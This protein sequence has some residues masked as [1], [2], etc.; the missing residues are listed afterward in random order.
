MRAGTLFVIALIPGVAGLSPRVFGQ[1]LSVGVIGGASLT[2][3]APDV[4]T[5]VLPFR[6]RFWSPTRDWVAG[7]KLELRFQSHF[8]VEVDGMYRELHITWAAVLA[9]GSLN[10]V[11]PSPVV[12]WEF[13]V[14]A[15]YRF[16]WGRAAPF[17]EAGPSFRTTG[18][19]NSYPSHYGAAAG[20][21]VETRVA[22]VTIAPVVR[23]TRWAADIGYSWVARTRQN[24]VELLVG[25]SRA[26]GT[27]WSPLGGRV[28]LGAVAGWGLNADLPSF[29]SAGQTVVA[30]PQPGGGFTFTTTGE[31]VRDTGLTSL[32]AGPSVEV[33]LLP[34]LSIEC[35]ALHKPLRDRVDSS[36]DNGAPP[37]TQTFTNAVT[38]QFPVLAKY[39]VSW[40]RVAP[41]VE[42]GPSFR[43]PQWTLSTHGVTA[44]AGV[45]M[46]FRALRIAPAVRFTHWAEEKPPGWS[47][48]ARNETSLL[49][50][51]SFGGTPLTVR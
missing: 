9:D 26:A 35:D 25:F 36:F 39:R 27:N 49:V 4:T 47:G 28:S 44:G 2:D 22:G 41:F 48:V 50:G 37:Q 19:L 20:V 18:N 45:Q 51:F 14:L 23:Y 12:T 34:R 38:W 16:R 15:K 24:Q 5:G 1:N 43:L 10:S 17:F 3:A 40:G 42:A 11:S 8:A 7:V 46:H 21:G 30:V 13:P 31:T 6:T 32:L 29:V 33:Q